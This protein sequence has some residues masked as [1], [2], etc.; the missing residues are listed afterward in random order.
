[1]NDPIIR[2]RL[3]VRRIKCRLLGR[4]PNPVRTMTPLERKAFEREI[5]R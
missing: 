3:W 4:K 2:L 5:N 1:M